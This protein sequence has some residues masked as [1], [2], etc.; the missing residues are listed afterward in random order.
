MKVRKPRL[1]ASVYERIS[2]LNQ[3]KKLHRVPSTDVET[4][5]IIFAIS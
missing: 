4:L 5:F 1:S 3:L 2:L